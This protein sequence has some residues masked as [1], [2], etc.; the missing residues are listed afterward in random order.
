MSERTS[1]SSAVEGMDHWCQFCLV[2]QIS[3]GEW[4]HP[5]LHCWALMFL[6]SFMVSSFHVW[7]FP[8]SNLSYFKPQLLVGLRKSYVAVFWTTLALLLS[9]VDKNA[10][11]TT[12]KSAVV[13]TD[14]QPV[15][16]AFTVFLFSPFRDEFQVAHAGFKVWHRNGTVGLHAPPAADKTNN[17]DEKSDSN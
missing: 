5:D 1:S 11:S 16:P 10:S 7:P 17:R 9:F 6:R 3:D 14:S 13:R 12:A 2:F 15:V 4:T 8:T